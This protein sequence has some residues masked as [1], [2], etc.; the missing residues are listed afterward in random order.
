MHYR[1]TKS[2]L[3]QTL[4]S[5]MQCKLNILTIKTEVGVR[6]KTTTIVT[7]KE[8]S[9]ISPLGIHTRSPNRFW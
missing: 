3:L 5:K 4:F 1:V 9:L 2:K 8:D 7:I 6:N